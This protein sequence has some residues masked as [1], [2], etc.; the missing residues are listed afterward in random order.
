MIKKDKCSCGKLKY[1][2]A[3]HCQQC[4]RKALAI[5]ENNP[6]FGVHRIG[7]ANPNYKGIMDNLPTC[8]QCNKPLSRAAYYSKAKLCQSCCRKKEWEEHPETHYI[9]KGRNHGS[10]GSPPPHSKGQWY[11][12]YYMRSSWEILFAKFL[13]ANN[14]K[15]LYESKTFDLGD[16]TYTPDFYLLDLDKYIEIKGWWREAYK[17]KFDLFKVF[18]PEIKIQVINDQDLNQLELIKT[19]RRKWWI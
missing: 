9:P 19:S 6:M 4:Y 5:P 8:S 12:D 10:F 1:Y 14:V 16:T 11:K 13:D 18:Y 7:K 15:W 17:R 2:K 3:K